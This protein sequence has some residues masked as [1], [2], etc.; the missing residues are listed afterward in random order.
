MVEA[1]QPQENDLCIGIDL[2]T[3]NSVVG[4]WM[5]NGA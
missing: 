4:L 2:G 1:E 5:D 3:C